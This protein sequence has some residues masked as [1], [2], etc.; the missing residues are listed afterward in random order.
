MRTL[1]IALLSV[2]L[3]GCG[4]VKQANQSSSCPAYPNGNMLTASSGNYCITPST[5]SYQIGQQGGLFN[6][7]SV[8]LTLQSSP[9]IPAGT[10]IEG[11]LVG[12]GGVQITSTGSPT[13]N[14]SFT[15]TTSP[16]ETCLPNPVSPTLSVADAG[17]DLQTNWTSVPQSCSN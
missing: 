17:V 12:L 1:C 10:T 15:T 8:S 7:Y 3:C 9:P 5:A 16:T 14:F 6:S 13:M 11:G 2:L 4:A